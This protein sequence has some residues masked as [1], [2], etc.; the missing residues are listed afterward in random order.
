M[1]GALT[2]LARRTENQM[3][4][5]DPHAKVEF[6]VAEDG[7]CGFYA[8]G[9]EEDG[10][11][12]EEMEEIS[13]AESVKAFFDSYYEA[14]FF[15]VEG[16][17]MC[18]RDSFWGGLPELPEYDVRLIFSTM[19]RVLARCSARHQRIHHHCLLYTSR[20]V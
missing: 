15:D 14:G 9:T 11:V 17:Q 16:N 8:A 4:A 10:T 19:H 20:C 18:I 13:T 12:A 7:S 2:E 1:V 3:L 6:R 5:V